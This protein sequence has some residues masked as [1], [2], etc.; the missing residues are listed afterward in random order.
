M[1]WSVSEH[2]LEWLDSSTCSM[3]ATYVAKNTVQCNRPGHAKHFRKSNRAIISLW[4]SCWLAT[5]R[6]RS[7]TD[8]MITVH[9]SCFWAKLSQLCLLAELWYFKQPLYWLA[10]LF[11]ALHGMQSR[12]SDGNSVCLSV[13]LSDCPSVR[14]S[15]RPSVCPSVKRVHCDKT[16]EKSVRFLYHAK[17]HSV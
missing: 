6:Q 1:K 3:I 4:S 17:D 5:R 9:L 15:V 11:T 8:N 10:L 13:C 16:E 12:Y 2:C 14:P 7:I